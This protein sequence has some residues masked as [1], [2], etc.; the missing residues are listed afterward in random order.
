MKRLLLTFVAMC[1]PLA[2]GAASLEPFSASYAIRWGGMNAGNATLRL[3]RIPG[4]DMWSYESRLQGRGLFRLALPSNQTARSVFQIRDGHVVPLTYTSSEKDQKVD[5]DWTSGRVTGSVSGKA[6]DLPVQEG[7]LDEQAVQVAL[8][9]ELM[10][11]RTPSRFVLVDEG[12]I[13]D[14]RY[15]VEG[16]EMI[17]SAAGTFR[18]DIYS[19]RRPGSRKATYFWCAPELGYIPLKVERRDGKDVEWSMR[20]TSLD[21]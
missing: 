12:R 19:S 21:R 6:F 15:A 1:L 13:K 20:L 5:F 14:Y 17:E 10:S 11:G 18:T 7:L 3:D 16:S 2:A 9:Q 8:M 4:D